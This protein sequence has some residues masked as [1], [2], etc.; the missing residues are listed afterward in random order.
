MAR[1]FVAK[2]PFSSTRANPPPV[3]TTPAEAVPAPMR[4]AAQTATQEIKRVMSGRFIIWSNR[5][6]VA[7]LAGLS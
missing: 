3:V 2:V 5:G 1:L 7:F 6:Y 4:S